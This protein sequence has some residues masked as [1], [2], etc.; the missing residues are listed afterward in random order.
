MELQPDEIHLPRSLKEYIDNY[1]YFRITGENAC[2]VF[3]MPLGMVQII[4]Q[5]GTPI[6]HNTSFSNG[7]RMRPHIFVGGPFDTAYRMKFRPGVNIFS[8]LFKPGK[9]KYFLPGKVSDYTNQLI[10][11]E[12]IWGAEGRFLSEKIFLA[13]DTFQRVHILEQFLTERFRHHEKSFIES[14]ITQ[15]FSENGSEKIGDLSKKSGLSISQF[16]KR[17]KAET[18]LSPKTFQKIVRVNSL[19][20]HYSNHSG[21]SLTELGYRFNYF[22]QSHFIKDIKSIAG[23]PPSKVLSHFEGTDFHKY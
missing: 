18:G 23:I 11:P 13:K 14:S 3:M 9:A 16:R 12:D 2:S 10:V 5:S 1:S 4:F 7:W 8:A 6:L 21:M 22:D 19:L 17:F 20:S 15:I